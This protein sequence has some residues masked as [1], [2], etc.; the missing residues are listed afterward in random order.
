MKWKTFVFL[1]LLIVSGFWIYCEIDHGIAPLPGKLRATVIFKN[2]PAP[3][4]TEGIY[5][6]VAP[7]FP[8]HAINEMYH[9]PNSLPVDQD[10]VI[11][12]MD[13]PYGRYEAMSLWWY[14]TDITSNLADVMA[15][16]LDIHNN[17]MPMAFEIT[18]EA[19]V[20]E[21]S[22]YANW[23]IVDRTAAIEGTVSFNGPFPEN[24]AVTAVAAYR[25]IPEASVHYLSYLKSID[26]SIE[27]NATHS[28]EY[29]LPIRHGEINYIC[30]LWLPEQAA[31]TDFSTIGFY[32]D[33]DNPEEPGSLRIRAEE[34]ATN[35]NLE[36]D[37][38]LINI[39]TIELP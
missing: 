20:F 2:P 4:N 3:E 19:P 15:L 10:T 11:T 31:L 24:T 34:V 32:R 22:L 27:D 12:E 39:P 37:W 5:L 14:G 28:Y 13:L 7:N 30:V 35:I 1:G 9:S 23:N 36:A 26:F 16:P 25:Y 33:P 21:Y 17:L 29:R 6:I 18:P 38:S 8:P